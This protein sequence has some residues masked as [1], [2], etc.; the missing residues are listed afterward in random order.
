[1]TNYLPVIIDAEYISDYKIKI[2][3]NNGEQKVADFDKWLIGEVF[4]PL[5]D[6]NY[7]KKF[8]IDGWSI[9][10]PNGAD[11]SPETL[12]GESTPIN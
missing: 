10:W 1:M 6:K 11:I 7:F 8:F 12:Y 9:S 4:K 5:K 2:T 3:F